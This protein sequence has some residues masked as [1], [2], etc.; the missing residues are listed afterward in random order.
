VVAGKCT[1]KIERDFFEARVRPL[2]GPDA[3]WVGEA[4]AE[5]KADLLGR[6]RCL[7][8]PVQW[9]E[10]FGLVMVE[11]MACG[12]PVVA[13][14]A[15]AVPEV[16]EDGVTG[17]VCDRVDELPAA[18]ERA[19]ALEPKACRQRVV[20][21]FD[22]ARMAERYERVFRRVAAGPAATPS[23]ARRGR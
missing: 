5:Q 16:V 18:I 8:F 11:A 7:V 9:N 3:E 22:V 20:D 15:G 21:H 4:D 19:D 6:A 23:R 10:P 17:F 13:L 2:L 14:R 12:T 1:E